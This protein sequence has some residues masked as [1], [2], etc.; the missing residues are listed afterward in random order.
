MFTACHDDIIMHY[1]YSQIVYMDYTASAAQR[2]RCSVFEW[3]AAGYRLL[4]Q[5]VP[6]APG[7]CYPSALISSC[8]LIEWAVAKCR[9]D[10]KH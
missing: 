1:G 6:E 10:V 9:D 3:E 2:H 7:C 8:S 4:V 5:P